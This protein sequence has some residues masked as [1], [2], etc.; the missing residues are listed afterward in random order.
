MDLE[1]LFFILFISL[2]L[3]NMSS[4]LEF[5]FIKLVVQI[6]FFENL[7]VENSIFKISPK[8]LSYRFIF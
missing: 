6:Y 8:L 7:F 5:I 1:L 3:C 2:K 4:S